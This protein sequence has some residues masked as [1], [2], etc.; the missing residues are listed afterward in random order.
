MSTWISSARRT[1]ALI[2][3]LLS[4]CVAGDVLPSGGGVSR[5]AVSDGA[6]V[7]AGP[8][9]YCIDRQATRTGEGNAFVLLGSCAALGGGAAPV[10]RAVLTASVL[11]GAPTSQ[12]LVAAFADMAVFFRSPAG[13]AALSRSGQARDVT[14][15]QIETVKDVMVLRL[16]DTSASA[17]AAVAPDYWRAVFSV[18]G[19]IVSLSVLGLKAQP[20][21]AEGQ[22]R[23]LEAFVTRVRRENRVA[24]GT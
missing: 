24:S 20:L 15:R 1:L 3:V 23:L 5:V 10:A 13:R 2:P 14:I 12:P 22:R 19:R 16:N 21:A 6:V 8:P 18:R 7:I 4:A 17:G 9:G 11:A